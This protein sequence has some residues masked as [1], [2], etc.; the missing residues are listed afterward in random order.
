MSFANAKIIGDAV[1]AARDRAGLAATNAYRKMGD[2]FHERLKDRRFTE[3]HAKEAGYLPRAGESFDRASKEFKQ[4]Y[5]GRKLKLKGHTRPL[6][7]SGKTRQSTETHRVDAVSGILTDGDGGEVQVKYPQAR[8]L[9]RKSK[10]TDINMRDEFLR[11]TK[12]ERKTLADVFE[13]ALQDELRKG[14]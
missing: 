14:N 2:T 11:T 9:N 4:S 8:G 1:Q 13:K 6:E 10:F 3:K 5:L 12:A 7:F